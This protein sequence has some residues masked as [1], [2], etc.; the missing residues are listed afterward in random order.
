[1]VVLKNGDVL[2]T[3]LRINETILLPILAVIFLGILFW[4]IQKSNLHVARMLVFAVLFSYLY[5]LLGLTLF[6]LN[7]FA[8]GTELY[9]LG[10]GKAVT[11]ANFNLL[12]LGH[13]RMLQLI[14][15]IVLFVP[16]GFL[17]AVLDAQWARIWRNVTLCLSISVAI[18]VCQLLGT[19]FYLSTR[20]FDIGDI[21]L[22]TC[23]GLIGVMMFKTVQGIFS[24]QIEIIRM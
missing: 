18:E 10:F 6:P 3:P 17:T 11:Q 21:A 2:I 23:G 9:H 24:E 5:V 15:N 12:T 20:T 8:P 16:L 14:G 7:V 19:Y 4:K 13:Y 22:N 1:M